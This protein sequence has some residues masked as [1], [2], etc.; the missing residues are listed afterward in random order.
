LTDSLETVTTTSWPGQKPGTSGLRKR[1]TEYQQTGYLENF[2]QS[3]FNTIPLDD[4]TTLVLGGDGR[5]FNR[6]AARTIIAMAAANGFE[7]VVVGQRALLSTPAVSNLIRKRHCAGGIVLSASHNPG[8][9]D[10]DFGVKFN[11]ASGA[12]APESVTEA[13][14][15][16]TLGI[17]EYRI[18]RSPRQI[19]L[20]RCGESQL[21]E[22][23]VEVVDAVDDYQQTMETVFDFDRLREGFRDG[24]LSVC[25]DAM[26]A[27]TGPYAR[28]IL[29]HTLGAAPGSVIN[30]I[31]LEDFGG[32]HPDPNLEH[33]RELLKRMTAP[34]APLLGAASDG[35]GD[36][37]LIV[38][39]DFFV[40]P[41]DSLALLTAHARL[42]PQ[43][44]AGLAG[45]A[46]S[47]PTSRAVD[48][49]ARE[50]GIG[51]HET[52]TGW[53]YFGNLLDAG[54]INLCGEESFGTG[55]D[56]VRE[57][58]G[59]WTVLAWLT[60]L[61]ELGQSVETIVTRH[62][63]HFGR[64]VYC[65]HD[66]EGIDPDPADALMKHLADSAA[67][68][69]GE[70]VDGVGILSVQPFFYT[71]PVDGV[72]SGSQGIQVFLEE[73]SR[74]VYRLSGTGTSGATLRVYL[75]QY[76]ES[77]NSTNALE[78][79]AVLGKRAASIASIEYH[80]GMLEPS[81]RT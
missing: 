66:Y 21:A 38:G 14:H 78:A 49:V 25:F 23:T 58:D 53:K 10:G 11:N 7:R 46:R 32:G 48:R 81:L 45:V 63:Q 59:L 42:I 39:R 28:T 12:P 68:M 52:P 20:D 71:D 18:C 8:G 54:L 27:V 61:V 55:G 16:E 70:R 3:I 41:S 77:A 56:H 76:Q 22:M 57:K 1:V 30:G 24:R 62:W 15:R 13:I 6:D 50:L 67:R 37:N 36:R 74:I 40:T 19:D 4:R 47:M 31:P 17:S 79:N 26:H 69:A 72:T 34:D 80:T 35:D 33:A 51:C 44:S 75:E 2:I 43:F 5:Y 64:Y 29:E 9:I 60:L 73:G 65:R